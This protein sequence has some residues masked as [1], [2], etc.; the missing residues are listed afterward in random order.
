LQNYS[1]TGEILYIPKEVIL[2]KAQIVNEL[3]PA[4]V[5]TVSG[6]EVLI[7]RT[8]IVSF[9][10][11]QAQSDWLI[12]ALRDQVQLALQKAQA[13]YEQKLQTKLQ[14]VVDKTLGQADE[15]KNA[16]KQITLQADKNIDFLSLKKIMYSI[17]AGGSGQINF[18]VTK[19]AKD[20]SSTQ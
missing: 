16:W 20:A 12:P 11:V 6:K 9:A 13:D 1:A 8:P 2:P 7:D 14:N 17:Q 4:I 15:K 10:E 5:V 18:A 3:A 19:E